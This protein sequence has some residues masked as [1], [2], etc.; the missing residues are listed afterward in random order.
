MNCFKLYYPC[1]LSAVFHVRLCLG[2]SEHCAGYKA[3]QVHSQQG[4]LAQGHFSKRKLLAQ[5]M[6][7][8]FK[9]YSCWD[10][11]RDSAS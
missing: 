8:T 2:R 11:S 6:E 10:T 1:L 3:A 4:R 9:R 7:L 5:V